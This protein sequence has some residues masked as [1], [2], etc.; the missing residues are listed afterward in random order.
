MSWSPAYAERAP[1]IRKLTKL[2]KT[3]CLAI[4]RTMKKRANDRRNFSQ[5]A[6]RKLLLHVESREGAEQPRHRASTRV[7]LCP[8]QVK[9]TLDATCD[10]QR[11][12]RR[13]AMLIAE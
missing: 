8:Q 5:A 12:Q 3:P 10:L 9:T 11:R 4:I 13:C 2:S 1:I 7:V 6:D